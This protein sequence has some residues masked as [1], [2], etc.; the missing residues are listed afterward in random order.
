MEYCFSK[1]HRYANLNKNFNTCFNTIKDNRIV[2]F[3]YKILHHIL[4]TETL[5]NQMGKSKTIACRICKSIPETI[6]YFFVNCDSVKNIWNLLNDRLLAATRKWLNEISFH[7]I[8]GYLNNPNLCVLMDKI[9]PCYDYA[10]HR[11][12]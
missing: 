7:V 11:I 9:E 12:G 10:G 5:L 3:Q 1:N 4:D 2:C 6:Y 8:I